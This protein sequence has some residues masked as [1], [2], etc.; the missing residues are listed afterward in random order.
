MAAFEGR[1]RR[2]AS[3]LCRKIAA[4]GIALVIGLWIVILVE[5]RAE[6]DAA[7]EQAR[8]QGL[9]LSAAFAAEIGRTM[10]SIAGSMSLLADRLRHDLSSGRG[11]TAAEHRA[12]ELIALSRS[13]V[14]AAFIGPDGR[15]VFST[16][17]PAVSAS[18]F[19]A[20]DDFRYLRANRSNKPFVGEPLIATTD[21]PLVLPISRRVEAED[22]T[23]LGML[24]FSLVPSDLTNLHQAVDLGRRGVLSVICTSGMIRARFSAEHP[25]G[26]N[27]VGMS[28]VGGGGG[29]DPNL[30]P[31]GMNSY[32]R[33]GVVDHV[34]RMF[35][36][37]RLTDHDLVVSVGLD[38]D[39][40]LVSARSH[41]AL[42]IAMGTAAS[43]LLGM[44][45]VLLVREIWRRTLRE[46]E[47]AREH[48][49]LE[50]ANAQILRDR[51]KLAITN[52]ELTAT[53]EKAE[54]ASRAKSQFLANMSH[55]LR[56]PLHAIIGFSELI[57]SQAPK[58]VPKAPPLGEYAKDILSAGRHL[59]ELINTILDLAKVESG[60]TLLSETVVPLSDIVHASMIAI[61]S[62]ARGRNIA[63]EV[64][65]PPDAPA[66]RV[67]L[68]KA[69]QILINILS[70][71]VKFTP[72]GGTVTVAAE[73][74]PH[75]GVTLAVTDT[76]IGMTEAE[77]AV[78][79]EPFGQVD[80]TLARVAEGTGL[81]LPLAQRLME[82]HGGR[83]S[84]TS[85][86]HKGTRVM[87]MFPPER[88][89]HA[90][91]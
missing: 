32:I 84:M 54:A 80:S 15:A 12:A 48:G 1:A 36:Q 31:G 18:D 45:T 62:Q 52:R 44:L 9:N 72:E 90:P 51:E 59:L 47:L 16:L 75:G 77:M 64:N 14:R 60:T 7:M 22:G 79:M 76:G 71:A 88:V 53:A 57:V 5:I 37:R 63:L 20:R 34:L 67:D 58:D 66:L 11:A 68:T 56:T 41:K 17:G 28:V 73:R 2:H 82:M 19:S 70:N 78:A 24:L 81:G 35:S 87:L 50:E 27:G 30:P 33:V 86:K 83:L 23:F 39:D 3:R 74:G 49:R 43:L 46:I 55:E 65:L 85:E 61:R 69:R 10:D 6:N 8:L 29:W 25:D 4:A 89:V 38:V 13:A 26:M 42:I 21:Q 91:T 40:V